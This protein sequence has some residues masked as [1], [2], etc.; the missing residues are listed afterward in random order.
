MAQ[1]YGMSGRMTDGDADR[2]MSIG[3]ANAWGREVRLA[4]LDDWNRARTEETRL[5]EVVKKQ[6]ER[7]AGLEAILRRV[8]KVMSDSPAF[9][10]WD[11]GPASV[12]VAVRK[13]VSP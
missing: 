13:A 5:L 10:P 8:D 7:I 9:N 6:E 12:L 2:A 1:S 3:R 11:L 4:A